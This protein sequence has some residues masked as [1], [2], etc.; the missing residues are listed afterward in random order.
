MDSNNLDW[1]IIIDRIDQNN[2]NNK[3]Y[4]EFWFDFFIMNRVLNNPLTSRIQ[5]WFNKYVEIVNNK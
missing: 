4:Y 3:Y 1:E 5:Y 2:V